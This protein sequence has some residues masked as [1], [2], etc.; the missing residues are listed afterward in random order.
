MAKEYT[1]CCPD[2]DNIRIGPDALFGE[3]GNGKCKHCHGEG[4]VYGIGDTIASMIMLET[5]PNYHDCE[6]CSKTGQ[7]Q[8]C[9]GTGYE[10]SYESFDSYPEKEEKEETSDYYYDYEYPDEPITSSSGRNDED[11]LSGIV[12]VIV[13]IVLFFIVKEIFSCNKKSDGSYHHS[14]VEY[15]IQ[16]NVQSQPLP[17]E[18]SNTGNYSFHN[19]TNNT[20]YMYVSAGI[21]FQNLVI[22]PGE[23]V[24]EYDLNANETVNTYSYKISYFPDDDI[25]VAEKRGEI[26]VQECQTGLLNLNLPK[27]QNYK[28]IFD[29]WKEVNLSSS[30]CYFLIVPSGNFYVRFSPD[31]SEHQ[32]YSWCSIPEGSTKIYVKYNFEEKNVPMAII[33]DTCVE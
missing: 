32:G 3:R 22:P 13:I 24:T 12:S 9:G 10:Y 6:V 27:M 29:Q 17:C 4:I 18:K 11:V 20:I 7:C 1:R 2:C 31:D 25:S 16:Q 33:K 28:L 23:T 5:I 19:P 15:P 8:T 21:Y 26:K 30:G 14:D